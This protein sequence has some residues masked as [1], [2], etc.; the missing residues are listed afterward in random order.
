MID[1]TALRLN[2]GHSIR[3]LSVELG[4]HQH[5]IRRLEAGGTIHPASAKKIADKFGVQVTDVMPVEPK[6]EAA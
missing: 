3:S 6:R 1:L 4:V 2:A 5:A